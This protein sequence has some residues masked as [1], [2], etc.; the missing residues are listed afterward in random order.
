MYFVTGID[1]NWSGNF[2]GIWEGSVQG[3]WL[4]VHWQGFGKIF[5]VHISYCMDL[6]E[7]FC[8]DCDAIPQYILKIWRLKP[9]TCSIHCGFD[10]GQGLL[11]IG[12]TITERA[13]ITDETQNQVV[14]IVC[15]CM[16]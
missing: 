2:S 10:G 11:K 7:V 8:T 15:R 4:H 14:L 13:A 6:Y 9:H 1:N 16:F 5:T 12:L 3:I